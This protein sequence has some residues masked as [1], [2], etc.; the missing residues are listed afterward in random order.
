MASASICALLARFPRKADWMPKKSKPMS[1]V[2]GL[3]RTLPLF[4][5][6]HMRAMLPSIASSGIMLS[7]RLEAVVSPISR[8]LRC[9]N[10]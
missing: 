2:T 4:L 7:T 5:F 10:Q 6:I 8:E 9:V 3:P 1:H